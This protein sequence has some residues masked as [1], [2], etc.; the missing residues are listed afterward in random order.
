[1]S[2]S[3]SSS[4]ERHAS[5]FEREDLDVKMLDSPKVRFVDGDAERADLSVDPSLYDEVM[6]CTKCN[7]CVSLLI[8]VYL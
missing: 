8:D 7:Y 1:M 2:S 3:G 4:K 6:F 5:A